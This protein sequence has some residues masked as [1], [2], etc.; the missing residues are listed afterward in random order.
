MEIKVYKAW[1]PDAIRKTTPNKRIREA[2]ESTNKILSYLRELKPKILTEYVPALTKR[3]TDVVKDFQM[4]TGFL[5]HEEITKDLEHLNEHSKLRDAII[6]YVFKH[7]D[8]P[9]VPQSGSEEISVKSL[10]TTKAYERL[11][12]HRAKT[13]A[14]LLGDEQAVTL[15]KRVVAKRLE[16][17]KIEYERRQRE[18][19]EKG[20]AILSLTEVRERAIKRWTEIGLGDFVACVF[21]EHSEVFRFDCCITHE[22]LKDLEDPDW[23]YLATCYIGDAP[24]YNTF[25]TKSLRRTQTLH[26]GDFCDEFYWDN[27]YHKNPKQPDLEFTRSLGRDQE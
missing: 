9:E 14:D 15:W 22:A 25:G 4:D 18:R 17:E 23:A 2:L 10:N 1:N 27:R 26:H 8:L 6:L 19:E 16:A 3:L 5:D 12:Y 13:L 7:L 21:D 11:A 24:E 20:E